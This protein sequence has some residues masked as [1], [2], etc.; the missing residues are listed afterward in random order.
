MVLIETVSV[1]LWLLHR[2]EEVVGVLLT[3]LKE[4]WPQW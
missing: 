4:W 2:Y 1:A 3:Q